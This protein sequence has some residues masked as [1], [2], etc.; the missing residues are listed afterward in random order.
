[1]CDLLAEEVA[2]VYSFAFQGGS[3]EAVT[4]AEHLGVQ[5]QSLH[6]EKKRSWR[7]EVGV[8]NFTLPYITPTII[9][10][11]PSSSE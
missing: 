10:P 5:I 6:L 8:F 9:F 1:M 4:D 2:Q 7:H 11:D 3:E